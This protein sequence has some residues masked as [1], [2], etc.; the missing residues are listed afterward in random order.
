M[1]GRL[2]LDYT[3][4]EAWEYLDLAGEPPAGGV[5]VL[6]L[7]P[8]TRRGGEIAWSRVPVIRATDRGRQIGP[9]VWPLVPHWLKGELP[10]FS[11]ANCRSEPDRPFSKTVSGK[12]AFRN[13]WKRDQ[14]CLVPLSWFYEWDQRTRPKQPWRVHPKNAPLLVAAGL[15]E[16]SVRDEGD[17]LES[18]TILTTE[19]NQ[20]LR[21]IGHHRAPVLLDGDDREIWLTGPA[22]RAERLVRAP[23]EASL[24][25]H[26]VSTRVNNPEYQG[27]DLLAELAG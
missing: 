2:G 21:D 27:E 26:R 24:Q 10:K 18:F 19:P 14:R 17:M 22:E 25:A 4:A 5:R 6:N 13:A 12:P 15:W 8:S 20:L 11:T 16:R 1:C 9:L 23:R 7:A 3:W